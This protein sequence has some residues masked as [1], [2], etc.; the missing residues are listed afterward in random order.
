MLRLTKSQVDVYE[1]KEKL[2]KKLFSEWDF[3]HRMMYFFLRAFSTLN[4]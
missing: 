3:S 1:K 2:V 4:S